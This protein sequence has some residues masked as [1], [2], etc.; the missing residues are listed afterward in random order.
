MEKK[1]RKER[2][3]VKTKKSA[4]ATDNCNCLKELF[5]DN[6]P[7]VTDRRSRVTVVGQ[8]GLNHEDQYVLKCAATVNDKPIET[9]V[10]RNNFYDF[11]RLERNYDGNQVSNQSTQVNFNNFNQDSRKRNQSEQCHC[12]LP[13]TPTSLDTEAGDNV[14]KECKSP[15]VIISVYPR[16]DN[17]VDN[18]AVKVIRH[19]SPKRK[20]VTNIMRSNFRQQ[21][22][23]PSPEKTNRAKFTKMESKFTR[24]RS[25]SPK[26]KNE[27]R[28]EFG[29]KSETSSKNYNALKKGSPQQNRSP[30]SNI[31]NKLQDRSVCHCNDKSLE[32]ETLDP[33]KIKMLAGRSKESEQVKKALVNS[34]LQNVNAMD[35]YNRKSN[36]FAPKD[37]ASKVTIN[38]DGDKERYDV[39]LQHTNYDAGVSIKKTI[40]PPQMDSREQGGKSGKSNQVKGKNEH[41]K[42]AK[43][44]QKDVKM[45]PDSRLNIRDS[46]EI[47]KSSKS[48]MMGLSINKINKYLKRHNNEETLNKLIN[49]EL[50]HRKEEHI[51]NYFLNQ[52]LRP[53]SNK[54]KDTE[55]PVHTTQDLIISMPSASLQT[56]EEDS[57]MKDVLVKHNADVIQNFDIQNEEHFIN[58]WS[59]VDTNITSIN[60]D[61]SSQ[62]VVLSKNIQIFLQVDQFRRKKSILL[63]KKQYEKVKRIV[64]RKISKKSSVVSKRSNMKTYNVVSVGE[65]KMKPKLKTPLLIERGIQAVGNEI[66]TR[67]DSVTNKY[68]I[69]NEKPKN[70]ELYG[71]IDKISDGAMFK[72]ILQPGRKPLRQAVSSVEIRYAQVKYKKCITMTSSSTRFNKDVMQPIQTKN[73]QRHNN[74]I[75]TIFKGHKK[76]VTPN[77]GTSAYSLY[78]NETDFSYKTNKLPHCDGDYKSKKPFL[79]RLISCIIMR[80]NETSNIKDIVRKETMPTLNSSDS[81]HLSTSLALLDMNSSLYDTSASFYSN[82]T[83]LPVNKMKK[84]FFSS[85]RE[86]LRRS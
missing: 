26:N 37:D 86:F 61:N 42:F 68:T 45:K 10:T 41:K 70:K 16:Q 4:V 57:F 83:I 55:K 36:V 20:E 44:S 31:I 23:E 38:I 60:D 79:Q 30:K 59:K 50:C 48:T 85:V 2:K 14:L 72:N 66:K 76:S 1:R 43:S 5:P 82:H 7:F 25:S 39:L 11:T 80:S 3:N 15:L 29:N 84:G 74:S 35:R 56:T 46:I 64:E 8:L 54:I 65:I 67:D 33:N 24:S 12:S 49:P 47:C 77:L 62:N 22:R 71:E 75:L 73:I 28:K 32:T 34:F 40:K 9:N 81:Y 69:E 17:T 18:D 52:N 21:F 53:E 19:T 63:T 51:D 13:T 6:L 78:S 58:D 27:P